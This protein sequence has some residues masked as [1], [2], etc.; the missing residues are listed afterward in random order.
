VVC[1]V[2]DGLRPDLVSPD[3]TPTLWRL[4]GRGV[5][6]ERARTVFPSE[7][8]VA[9]SAFSTGS[10]PGRHGMPANVFYLPEHDPLRPA[11]A[12]DAE[13]LRELEA[14]DG[15]MLFPPT[16]GEALRDA[17]GVLAVASAGSTG[18][19]TLL[20]PY[21]ADGQTGYVVNWGI[22]LPEAVHGQVRERF[23]APPARGVPNSGP[24]GWVT[25]VFCEWL[26]PEVVAQRE[27]AV[28]V[29]WLSE[30]DVTLHY[31]GFGSPEAERALRDCD[32][33][34]ARVVEAMAAAGMRVEGSDANAN[35]FILSDHGHT[36]I[37]RGARP[38][39]DDVLDGDWQE[40]RTAGAIVVGPKAIWV[41]PAQRTRLP[42]LVERLMAHPNVGPIFA[43]NPAGLAG[44][45]PLS[46]VNHGGERAPDLLF[47]PVW[48]DD[49]HPSG[50]PGYTWAPDAGST[51]T[52]HGSLS[53]FDMRTTL[54]AVGA[55]FREGVRS[56]VPA[57][58]VD[59][60]PT[61]LHLLDVP[62]PAAWDGRPLL[63]ALRGGPDPETVEVQEGS[64]GGTTTAD[65][66]EREQRVHLVRI[67]QT[68]Y[69]D[70]AT[71]TRRTLG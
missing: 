3:V 67:A 9:T 38:P 33:L 60:A 42:G 32:A 35:L 46:A 51:V 68:T 21:A 27:P 5:W 57:G 50:V 26:L 22:A 13:R 8:R 69:V 70:H 25:R 39:L 17:G 64:I 36:T 63:E 58:I 7:T 47:S 66:A 34:L 61:A 49:V 53:P 6:H 31:R 18:N 24:N 12:A 2:W 11:S 40:A 52:D 71:L 23:G 19:A 45:L 14:R 4:A 54:V 10:Y 41:R 56:H 62:I 20:N 30:P 65:G 15:R 37:R 29:L 1:V 48:L 55:A 16:L 44:V 28:G 59:V 43:A